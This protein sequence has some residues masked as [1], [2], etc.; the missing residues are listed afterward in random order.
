MTRAAGPD[1][2]LIGIEEWFDSTYVGAAPVEY[3]FGLIAAGSTHTLAIKSDGT[4]WAWGA[5]NW[6]QLGL[7]EDADGTAPS[8]VGQDTKW[9]SV[10]AGYYHTVAVKIDGTLWAWG[11]NL[12]G[13]L[14]LDGEANRTAP[15]QV[16]DD[17]DWASV[18]AGYYHTVAVKIDGTLWAWGNN[19]YG[20]L[21]LVDGDLD[22]YVPNQ[23]GTATDWL[24]V[25]AGEYHNIAFKTDGTLWA[26]GANEYGQLGL[27]TSDG[28]GGIY[29]PEQIGEDT[30]WAKVVAGRNFNVATK[31]DGS[32]W[33]WGNNGHGQLGLGD[34][35]WDAN[36]TTPEQIG[37]DTDWASV[38]AGDSY[39]MATKTDGSL[40]AWGNNEHG[41][42]GFSDNIWEKNVPEQ[43]GEDTDWASVTAGDFHS[44]AIKANGSLWAWGNNGHGQLGLNTLVH[45]SYSPRFVMCIAPISPENMF[46]NRN[47]VKLWP[48]GKAALT[49]IF[50]PFYA[51]ERDVAWSS[52]DELVAVVDGFGVVTAVAEGLATITG[53]AASGGL[54]TECIVTVSLPETKINPDEVCMIAAGRYHTVAIR[55]DGSLWAWGANEYGQL[56]LGDSG[57]DK[58]RNTPEQ[59]GLDTDWASVAA[60]NTHT[61][62]IKNDGSLWIW[63]IYSSEQPSEG[64]Y[65]WW[66]IVDRSAPTSIGTDTDWASVAAGYSHTIAVK[67]DGSLWAWGDNDWGQLGLGDRGWETFRNSP[68][69]IGKD[70]DW[71]SVAAGH[72]HTLAIKTDDSLWAWGNNGIG[73]LGLGDGEGFRIIPKQVGE[74][75]DWANV[76]AGDSHTLAIKTG[77]SLWAWGYNTNGQLGLDV[78]GNRNT[79]EQIGE[80]TDWASVTAGDSHTVAIKINGSLWAW[81]ANDGGQLG[82]GDTVNR[83]TPVQIGTDTDWASVAAGGLHT[84]A[85]MTNGNLYSW[86]R[87]GSGQL[88]DSTNDSSDIPIFI[89]GAV[90]IPVTGVALNNVVL[91]SGTLEKTAILMIGNTATLRATV[92]PSTAANKAIIWNSSNTAVASVNANGLVTTV[93]EGTA[94]ITVTTV[95]GGYSDECVIIVKPLPPKVRFDTIDSNVF[96]DNSPIRLTWSVDSSGLDFDVDVS[97]TRNNQPFTGHTYDSGGVTIQQQMDSSLRDF[98]TVR[99]TVTNKY[100]DSGSDLMPF[101]V[102]NHNALADEFASEIVIDNSN[103]IAGKTSIDILAMRG[104]LTLSCFIQL[105]TSKFPWSDKDS[106][107]FEISDESVAEI[108]YQQSNRLVKLTPGIHIHPKTQIRIVGIREGSATL[109]A[110]HNRTGMTVSVPVSVRTLEDKLFVLGV[111]PAVTT[112]VTYTNISGESVT[113]YTNDKGEIAIYEPGGIVGEIIF[114]AVSGNELY[115]GSIHSAQLYTSEQGLLNSQYYPMNTPIK[116]RRATNQTFY[117]YLPDGKPYTG[118]VT[119]YGGLYKNGEFVPDSKIE[120]QK[121]TAGSGGSF[122]ITM[123]SNAFGAI[124]SNNELR[125][126]YEV[127]FDGNYAPQL[128]FVDGFTN[129]NDNIKLGDSILRLQPWNKQSSTAIQYLYDSADMTDNNTYIDLSDE[130]KEV[131]LAAKIISSGADMRSLSYV[132]EFGHMPTKQ[133]YYL[134]N[135]DLP[136]TSGEYS[137]YEL[138]LTVGEDLKINSGETRHYNIQIRNGNGDTQRINLPFGIAN[139]VS[140]DIPTELLYFDFS[141]SGIMSDTSIFTPVLK[142]GGVGSVAIDLINGLAPASIPVP[143]LLG[144]KIDVTQKEDSPLAYK[145]KGVLDLNKNKITDKRTVWWT[146]NGGQ[147]HADE[148]CPALNKVK[149]FGYLTSG[150]LSEAISSG[151]TTCYCRWKNGGCAKLAAEFDKEFE[152]AKDDFKKTKSGNSNIKTTGYFEAEIGYDIYK[153]QWLLEWTELGISLEWKPD[154]TKYS[155]K[156]PIPFAAIPLAVTVEFNAGIGVEIGVKLLPSRMISGINNYDWLILEAKTDAYVRLRGA[157]GV[158]IWIA[159]A[160]VGVFGELGLSAEFISQLLQLKA[161]TRYKVNATVGVDM[162]WRIGPPIKIWKIKLYKEGRTVFWQTTK[163]TGWR[164]IFGDQ[165]LFTNTVGA[166]ALSAQFALF[167]ALV[168]QQLHDIPIEQLPADDPVF[169]GDENFAVAAW[170][171][172]NMTDDEWEE[173][174]DIYIDEDDELEMDEIVRFANLSEITVSTY[175]DNAWT[176]PLTLTNNYLPDVDPIVAVSGDRAVVVWQQMGLSEDEEDLLTTSTNLWYS[177]YEDGEWA[178]V[179]RFAASVNSMIS[180]YSVAMNDSNIA[181]ILSTYEYEDD[182][183]TESIHVIHIDGFGRVTQNRVTF[184]TNLNV[185]PQI[186]SYGN[187]FIFSYYTSDFSGN[188][189]I[190]LGIIEAD[191]KINYDF[192]QGVNSSTTLYGIELSHNYI[193]IA[194]KNGDAAISWVAYDPEEGRNAIYAVKLVD[195]NGV[196]MLS[197]PIKLE[198]GNLQD[199][200]ILTLHDGVMDNDGSITVWYNHLSSAEYLEY[201][202]YL[203]Y[204]ALIQEL[205]SGDL[206]EPRRIEIEE[207][208]AELKQ[209]EGE[210]QP[211]Q[212]YD[213]LASGEFKNSFLSMVFV[214]DDSIALESELP[215]H[216]NIINTG[217]NE[218]TQI[219]VDWGIGAKTTWDNSNIPLNAIFTATASVNINNLVERIPYTIYVTF[220]NDDI[221]EEKGVLIIARPDASIG[222]PVVTNSAHGERDFAFNLYSLS[223]VKLENSSYSVC[224]S[225]YKDLAHE[226]PATV[227]GDTIISD[228]ERLALIDEGGLSLTFTYLIAPD[229]LNEAGEIPS[230]GIRLFINAEILDENGNIVEESDYSA[231]QS[232]ILFES[233]L[234]YGQ[235]AVIAFV[236]QY[237]SINSVAD[238]SVLNRSMNEVPAN[239]G[240]IIAHLLNEDGGIIETQICDITNLLEKESMQN[241]QIA[242]SQSGFDVIVGDDTEQYNFL[243]YMESMQNSLVVGDTLYVDVMLVGDHNYTQ[244]NTAVAYDANLLEFA[245]YAN[246]SGLAAEV[247]QDGA[248][249][250]SVRSVPSLNMFAGAPCATPVRVVTLKFTVKA[251]ESVTTDLNF[252]SIAVTPTAGTTGATTAPGRPLK[253]VLNL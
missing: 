69:Q 100:N 229:D 165:T 32:L 57:W 150:T 129:N 14:G 135:N 178:E 21:G 26:W 116:M 76:A 226:I 102:Y 77:G 108:Y 155:Y 101:E 114:K 13:Q 219:V 140:L 78:E 118:G 67:T 20:Q 117:T 220:G 157:I 11:S 240:K 47:T 218:I 186:A 194:N 88:G 115:I 138:N 243:L 120:D 89:M 198:L 182:E 10:A 134:L 128:I 174:E 231:N 12:Y 7:S 248:D 177:I 3:D 86:G 188:S 98:Y 195:V 253:I 251:A 252:T 95:D 74:D 125:F 242:F 133:D 175:K 71:V 238:I 65:N 94:I 1:P 22:P 239:S 50:T 126:A 106:L 41:Q 43:V 176:E 167:N 161:A 110:T 59:I 154:S 38:S 192:S 210:V 216:F 97:V 80:D 122:T 84:L 228:I 141:L 196:L 249:K 209:P 199:D 72:S 193:L 39:S 27:G 48:G 187:G 222:R 104:E 15:E 144:F 211:P 52:S 169:A 9:A 4:L 90:R 235:D 245:G 159:M 164:P 201:L 223:D 54:T 230:E 44:M 73:Q 111:S 181:L 171:S 213:L 119:V 170:T 224:L 62:A 107:T 233:L 207:R 247:R 246:L 149:E 215:V 131:M 130:R 105:D 163:S 70:T 217:V 63:G 8:Q 241:Y 147:I 132:D 197:A 143:D 29:T 55:A 179:R 49:A 189:D 146:T 25:A 148:N 91:D 5:N 151:Q 185:R 232:N 214:G 33:T 250:I 92:S 18:A 87:N 79:P 212:S 204:N 19:S 227:I 158:D 203:E 35:G 85:I 121:L 139:M 200:A 36:R 42:L 127:I 191:G 75:N 82:L 103:K 234:R 60:G 64:S 45:A 221:V 24:S 237:D 112:E 83:I 17:R 162:T 152:K 123:D 34:S 136:F 206:T 124:N 153:K 166:R 184:D 37:E 16:G 145:V 202:E 66:L 180:G 113:R 6:G 96:L 183:I 160:S 156:I 46:L 23:V 2:S 61:V 58:Y 56:G 208:L 142:E 137:F 51:S 31:T 109:T 173:L 205:L 93:A 190:V 53:M 236:N 172:I 68:E 99:V 28:E 81:G 168:P 225:F 244:V 30:D 40:W